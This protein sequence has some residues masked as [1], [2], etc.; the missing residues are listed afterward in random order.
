MTSTLVEIQVLFS[1]TANNRHF[2]FIR[3]LET[4]EL[5]L[6]DSQSSVLFKR[7]IREKL[8]NCSSRSRKT[9]TSVR[10]YRFYRHWM[11]RHERSDEKSRHRS[12]RSRLRFRKERRQRVQT[13]RSTNNHQSQTIRSPTQRFQSNTQTHKV[14]AWTTSKRNWTTHESH[15]SLVSKQK[16][17]REEIT[18]NEIHGSRSISAT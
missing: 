9:G 16:I 18:S 17:Q 11:S 6:T 10:R 4:V 2:C 7:R 15:T 14:N 1:T 12:R 8:L 5:L 13:S 3:T